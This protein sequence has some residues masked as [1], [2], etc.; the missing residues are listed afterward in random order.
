VVNST[1]AA[2]STQVTSLLT[3]LGSGNA[4]SNKSV[5]SNTNNFKDLISN[6]LNSGTGEDNT[7]LAVD[8]ASNDKV[9][10]ALY[11]AASVL[12]ITG[13]INNIA[14]MDTGDIQKDATVAGI[15]KENN[16]SAVEQQMFVNGL[17]ITAVQISANETAASAASTNEKPVNNTLNL[18]ASKNKSSNIQEPDNKTLDVITVPVSAG[19][20]N[21]AANVPQ[22]IA[23]D[24][25]GILQNTIQTQPALIV[26]ASASDDASITAPAVQ[27]ADQQASQVQ[28][29]DR[30][31]SNTA[32]IQAAEVILTVPDVVADPVIF[33]ASKASTPVNITASDA[34][35][36]DVKTASAA[37]TTDLKTE[38]KQLENLTI[39]LKNTIDSVVNNNTNAVKADEDGKVE[40]AT[41]TANNAIKQITTKIA[42]IKTALAD[43]TDVTTKQ[44]SIKQDVKEII[45]DLNTALAAVNVLATAPLNSN[46]ALQDK[47]VSGTAVNTDVISGTITSLNTSAKDSWDS[48]GY[49]AA[50]AGNTD[51]FNS[52]INKIVTLLNDMNGTLEV[53]EKFVYVQAKQPEV[54]LPAVETKAAASSVSNIIKQATPAVAEVLQQAQV[55]VTAEQQSTAAAQIVAV[56]ADVKAVDDSAVSTAKTADIQA[57]PVT[58]VNEPEAVQF[59]GKEV[60]TSANNNYDSSSRNIVK[61]MKWVSENIIKPAADENIDAVNAFST[62]S[63]KALIFSKAADFAVSMKSEAI[64]NQVTSNIQNNTAVATQVHVISMVLKPENLGYVYIKLEHKDDKLTG[65]VQVASDDVKNVL[66]T[67]LPALKDALDSI[68]IKVDSFDV[69]TMNQN[70]NSG[71]SGQAKNPFKEWEGAAIVPAAVEINPAVESYSGTDEYLNYLA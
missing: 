11:E 67:N 59:S 46:A 2:N 32:T 40:A 16:L 52:V 48:S 13:N 66:K 28:P 9:K 29:A 4:N 37:A 51:E 41:V 21:T 55:T 54:V 26:L 64:L 15:I 65:S 57:G 12:Y 35:S 56:S 27:T 38:V 22:E 53:S 58:V 30:K 62:L 60:S 44:A 49:T 7:A 47:A 3:L 42:D 10:S 39:L 6:L 61:D 8:T 19:T 1:A 68:G 33:T 71:F 70:I 18:I 63:D 24:D 25:N 50:A 34:V 23:A 5:T 17:K 36:Q 45:S 43:D 31:T 69:S 20:T 14:S